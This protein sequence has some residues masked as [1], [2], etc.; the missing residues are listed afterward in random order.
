MHLPFYSLCWS[1]NKC[2]WVFSV[3]F[4]LTYTQHTHTHLMCVSAVGHIMW[5]RSNIFG[6]LLL[7]KSFDHK[8][9]RNACT[10]VSFS[11]SR[12]LFHTFFV[13]AFTPIWWMPHAAYAM[14]SH[15]S[16]DFYL[17]IFLWKI[18]KTYRFA[19]WDVVLSAQQSAFWHATVALLVLHADTTAAER[20]C[21]P[22]SSD[23]RKEKI[24]K[25]IL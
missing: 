16:F 14:H 20:W 24:A 8:F 15:S 18:K 19:L 10:S 22:S 3:C 13:P 9:H 2:V 1:N 5:Y 7:R 6:F 17:G 4:S 11:R 12:F 25:T 23:F 21:W